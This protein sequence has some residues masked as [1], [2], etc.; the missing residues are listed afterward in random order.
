MLFLHFP[1]HLPAHFSLPFAPLIPS[2][3]RASA[4]FHRRSKNFFPPMLTAG[5][6]ATHRGEGP[7]LVDRWG[8]AGAFAVRGG[9]DRDLYAV[10]SRHRS[11]G[12]GA[13]C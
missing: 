2:A 10:L 4:L 12:A 13:E 1:H 3:C 6:I 7:A 9:A 8:D 5:P 11:A